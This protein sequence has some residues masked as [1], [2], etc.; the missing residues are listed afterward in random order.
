MQTRITQSFL[1]VLSLI[2]VLTLPS[3]ASAHDEGYSNN[4][5]GVQQEFHN[6]P[7]TNREHI[8]LQRSLRRN[9]RNYY[10]RYSY[11]NGH[12]GN[13]W[14]GGRRHYGNKYDQG[15]KCRLSRRSYGNDSQHRPRY[16]G[17]DYYGYAR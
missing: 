3:A 15:K 1:A 5:G 7:Y 11:N 8:Q 14:Y 17:N 13:R 16:Y 6:S 10:D 4:R 12:F 2:G 9:S